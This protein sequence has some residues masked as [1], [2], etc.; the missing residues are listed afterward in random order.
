MNP[1]E[2]PLEQMYIAFSPSAS[3]AGPAKNL[4]LRAPFPSLL[5]PSPAPTN[6]C[7]LLQEYLSPGGSQASRNFLY[8]IGSSWLRREL[9]IRYN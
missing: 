9:P 4:Y 2:K 5:L 6:A 8:R 7:L 1:P 3:G